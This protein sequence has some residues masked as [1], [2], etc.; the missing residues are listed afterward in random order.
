MNTGLREAKLSRNKNG[1]LSFSRHKPGWF[2]LSL[3]SFAEGKTGQFHHAYSIA[4]YKNEYGIYTN[5]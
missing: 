2:A 4:P 5:N 1:S 3:N